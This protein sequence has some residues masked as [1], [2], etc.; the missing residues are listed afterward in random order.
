MS[1]DLERIKKL[2]RAMSETAS[3][4]AG[5]SMATEGHLRGQICSA[6]NRLN[7]ALGR[8]ISAHG[9]QPCKTCKEFHASWEACA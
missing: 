1:E 8:T 2:E 9:D 5:L 3:I 7:H 6:S 4:L